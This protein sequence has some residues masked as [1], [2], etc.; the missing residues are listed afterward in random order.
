MEKSIL[1]V[2]IHEKYKYVWYLRRLNIAETQSQIGRE[3]GL[4]DLESY[5]TILLSST[6]QWKGR[7]LSDHAVQVR[8]P[9]SGMPITEN[10]PF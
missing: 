3:P 2:A 1:V 5:S 9:S 6:A 4:Y 10:Y 8:I 7:W